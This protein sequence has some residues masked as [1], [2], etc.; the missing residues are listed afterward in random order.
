[1]V[2]YRVYP[3]D[4]HFLLK[5][6]SATCVT[7]LASTISETVLTMYLF[8]NLWRQWTIAF[9]VATP[10]LHLA[11]SAAQLHGSRVLWTMMVRQKRCIQEV[12]GQGGEMRSNQGEEQGTRQAGDKAEGEVDRGAVRSS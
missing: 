3:N 9:K 6:F 1:M 7:T 10:L 12:K 2:L 11:F 8:G 4:H 5:L